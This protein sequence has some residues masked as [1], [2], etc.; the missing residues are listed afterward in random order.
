MSEVM[1]GIASRHGLR[2]EFKQDFFGGQWLEVRSGLLGLRVSRLQISPRHIQMLQGLMAAQ[3]Q[4]EAV[5]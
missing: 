2:V 5:L 1:Q 4:V 3:H